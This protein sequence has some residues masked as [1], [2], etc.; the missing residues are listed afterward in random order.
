M[1]EG[2]NHASSMKASVE[3]GIL[4]HGV[5]PLPPSRS[6]KV[7]REL[8]L[9]NQ[10]CIPAGSGFQGHCHFTEV[11]KDVPRHPLSTIAAVTALELREATT[12]AP[13]SVTN[14]S[15]DLLAVTKSPLPS[16]MIALTPQTAPFTMDTKP[17]ASEILQQHKQEACQRKWLM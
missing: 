2:I 13:A 4:R 17:P 9:N 10:E 5:P 6:R 11:A 12:T 7:P 3:F 14:P 1:S 8:L 16:H 15:S